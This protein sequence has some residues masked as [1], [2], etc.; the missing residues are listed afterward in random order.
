MTSKRPIMGQ[1]PAAVGGRNNSALYFW[2]FGLALTLA[3]AIP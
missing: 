3:T 1:A 2:V